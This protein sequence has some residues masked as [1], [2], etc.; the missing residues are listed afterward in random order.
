M[1]HCDLEHITVTLSG[2]GEEAEA[3]VDLGAIYN[4]RHLAIRTKCTKRGVK[5]RVLSLITVSRMRNM[6]TVA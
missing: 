5:D 1:H 6:T 2:S 3:D 4:C